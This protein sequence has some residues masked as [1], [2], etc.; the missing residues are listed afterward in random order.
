MLSRVL[1]MRYA[2]SC[3]VTHIC[4]HYCP[5]LFNQKA[6]SLVALRSTTPTDWPKVC[7]GASERRRAGRHWRSACCI[8]GSNLHA[9]F[10][11]ETSVSANARNVKMHL[12]LVPHPTLSS[13][14]DLKFPGRPR[15]SHMGHSWQH[16]RKVK[17]T[18]I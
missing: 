10:V 15:G 12:H 16:Q 11:V 13:P 18:Q 7:N 14:K 6:S 17:N 2:E 8:S 9:C 3:L 5:H 4:L 1:L